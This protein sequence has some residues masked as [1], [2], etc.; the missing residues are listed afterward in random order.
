MPTPRRWTRDELLLAM[1]LYCRIPFGRQHAHA[2]EIIELAAALDR[3]PGSVAMKLNNLTSLDPEEQARGIKGLSGAS[4]LDR[5]VWAEFQA[6]W[7]DLALESETLW[8]QRV[9]GSTLGAALGTLGASDQPAPVPLPPTTL[10]TLSNP[11]P[12]PI[13]HQP[14][15]ATEALRTTRVR[16]AQSFFRR[17]ILSTYE[18]RC[19]LTGNPIP[20]LLEAAHVVSWSDRPEHRT[21]P[22]NGLCLTRLHH[23]ALDQG[24]IAFDTDCRLLLSPQLKAHLPNQTL[25]DNF[26]RY[27]GQPLRPPTRFPPDPSLLTHHRETIFIT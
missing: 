15:P 2:P 3:T 5:Q 18:T 21:N 25:Q 10:L 14:P 6:R 13:D 23:A 19:C 24:L 17:L 8:Q 1:H 27:E 9:T 12:S 20:G 22:K 26:T 7:D 4:D 11:Q 16:L